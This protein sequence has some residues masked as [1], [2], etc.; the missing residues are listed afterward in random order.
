MRPWTRGN[1]DIAIAPVIGLIA[2]GVA[3]VVADPVD[4]DAH[5]A[6]TAAF[7]ANL[8]NES[9]L[10]YQKDP[11]LLARGLVLGAP[12]TSK[13]KVMLVDRQFLA[14]MTRRG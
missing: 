5:V 11:G 4:R 2:F 9:D 12:K 3:I 7:L 1:L 14:R 8:Q 6:R 13:C 10:I